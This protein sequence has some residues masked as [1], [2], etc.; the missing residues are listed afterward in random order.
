ME[1]HATAVQDVGNTTFAAWC[2]VLVLR[3]GCNWNVNRSASSVLYGELDYVGLISLEQRRLR[4][5]YLEAYQ[6]M[7]GTDDVN[8]YIF[9][10]GR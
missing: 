9:P 3:K 7:R 6:I 5:D 1:C 2:T 4:R 10:P 8:S